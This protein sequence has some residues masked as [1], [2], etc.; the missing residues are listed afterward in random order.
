MFPKKSACDGGKEKQKTT[1]ATLGVKN[2]IT[3]EHDNGIC[4]FDLA[5]KNGMPKSTFFKNK[6]MIKAANVAKGSKVI[7]KQRT[8]IIEAVDKL[9]LMFINEKQE[10]GGSLSEAFIC[11]KT[12]DIY[13][14]LV[15]KT[16]CTN[17]KDFDF[18][19]SRG[20]FERLKKEV[21][22]TVHLDM[23]RRHSQTRRQRSSK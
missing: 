8:Q 16:L 11:K 23:E 19:A 13:G 18:K 9:L 12:L 7:S 22:F 20:W 15:K 21:E 14:D 10:K 3:A 5:S 1:R 4:V 2:E 17:F 6:E